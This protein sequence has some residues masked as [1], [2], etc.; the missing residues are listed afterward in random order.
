VP[1]FVDLTPEDDAEVIV[2]ALGPSNAEQLLRSNGVEKRRRE[3]RRALAT[4][5]ARSYVKQLLKSVPPGPIAVDITAFRAPTETHDLT[6]DWRS[7]LDNDARRIKPG[8]L[9][10]LEEALTDIRNEAQARERCPGVCLELSLPL[11]L[12][13]LVGYQWR[14]T[15]QLRTTVET[16]NPATGRMLR[17]EPSGGATD[18]RSELRKMA[19][20]GTGPMVLALSVGHSLG[21]TVDRYAGDVNARGFEHLH[22]PCDFAKEPL[23][24]ADIRGLAAHVVNRL[25]GLQAEG[26]PKHLLMRA[27]ANLAAAIGLAS[28]GIG[29]TW[30]PLYDGHDNYSGGITIG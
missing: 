22:V 19:L 15:T 29:P 8:G 23:D 3:S 17:V 27:P 20:P 12:A 28:N 4:R 10:V 11:P 1:V 2:A 9:Q 30:V 6:L 25:N 18:V 24:A 5:A 13:M 7:V 14:W 21:A 16:V 26:T